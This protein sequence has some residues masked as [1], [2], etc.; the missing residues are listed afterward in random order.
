[1]TEIYRASIGPSFM[2]KIFIRAPVKSPRKIT[3]TKN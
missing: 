1:M 2:Q 3:N